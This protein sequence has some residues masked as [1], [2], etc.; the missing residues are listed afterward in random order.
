MW[1]DYDR[2][3][4]LV[5]KKNKDSLDINEADKPRTGMDTFKAFGT[6]IGG[7]IYMFFPGGLYVTGAIAPYIATFFGV[8]ASETS[9]LLPAMFTLNSLLTPFGSYYT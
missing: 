5:D 3:N 6:V 7:F 4:T 1:E 2:E 8:G 9:Y